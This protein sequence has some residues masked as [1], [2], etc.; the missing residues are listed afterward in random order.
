MYMDYPP[1]S[2]P[3]L[4]IDLSPISSGILIDLLIKLDV[5]TGCQSSGHFTAKHMGV[6]EDV[7]DF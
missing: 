4:A 1:P 7:A 2:P 5:T 6:I 3:F